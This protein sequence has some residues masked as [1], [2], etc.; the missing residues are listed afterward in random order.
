[1]ASNDNKPRLPGEAFI[2]YFGE[3]LTGYFLFS[4]RC[5]DIPVDAPVRLKFTFGETLAE[6]A[7]PIDP[8]SGSLTRSWFQDETVNVDDV[9]QTVR[10][11][12]RYAF[13]H[14]KVSVKSFPVRVRGSLP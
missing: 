11:P 14:V 12:R 8:Y 10:L 9:P 2:L 13:H 3:H 6:V 1:M 7:E 5:F 4:L